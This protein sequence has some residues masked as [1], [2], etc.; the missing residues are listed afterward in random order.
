MAN[1]KKQANA[2]MTG[3]LKK[4]KGSLGMKG[5]KIVNKK[6][7]LAGPK[8]VKVKVGPKKPTPRK[9]TNIRSAY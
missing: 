2:A 4:S 7:L 1:I 3:F 8:A 5:P 6:P 9:R